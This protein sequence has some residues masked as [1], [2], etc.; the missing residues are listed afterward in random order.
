M[1]SAR[2]LG[3]RGRYG[4]QVYGLLLGLMLGATYRLDPNFLLM[5]QCLPGRQTHTC[6]FSHL[7]GGKKGVEDALYHLWCHPMTGI[8]HCQPYVWAYL[9]LRRDSRMV[10]R[11]VN[12]L[13]E[14]F[15]DTASLAHR[16]GRIRAEVE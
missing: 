1:I 14:H 10:S 11:D 13:Q 7:L 4:G 15:D 6:P 9:K 3:G 12:G 16:M 8:P 2:T 5:G